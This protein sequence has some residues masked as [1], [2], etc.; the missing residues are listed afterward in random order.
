[1]QGAPYLMAAVRCEI[2]W[3]GS[4]PGGILQLRSLKSLRLDEPVIVKKFLVK[5]FLKASKNVAFLEK[6]D[7]QKFCIFY[8]R[9]IFRQPDCINR[10]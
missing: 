10:L 1:M 6:G 3:V 7:T 5:L 8:Q 2:P 4:A 9:V